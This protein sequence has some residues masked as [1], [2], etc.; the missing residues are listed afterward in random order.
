[1]VLMAASQSGFRESG[2]I[3]LV[4]AN[5]EQPMPMVGVRCLGLGF[6]SIVGYLHEEDDTE[7]YLIQSLVTETYLHTLINLANGKFVENSK[8][9][10]SFRTTLLQLCSSG[11]L[12]EQTAIRNPLKV[13]WEDGDS[14]RER[15]RAEGLRRQ[16]ELRD[17]KKRHTKETE[18]SE[19]ERIESNSSGQ[20]NAQHNLANT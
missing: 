7:N 3:N 17:M 4:G 10:E 12:N 16:Q 14:R 20:Y 11:A 19:V 5:G 15:K 6:D 18:T 1:M 2:A 13:D 8:R 9:T